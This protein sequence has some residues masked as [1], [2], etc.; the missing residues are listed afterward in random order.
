MHR[1]EY[2]DRQSSNTSGDISGILETCPYLQRMFVTGLSTM[3]VVQHRHIREIYL[4]GLPLH[5]SVI[6]AL[7][8]CEFPALETL[9]LMDETGIKA[10]DL[11]RSLGSIGA[12]RLSSLYVYGVELLEFLAI[13]GNASLPWNLCILAPHFTD[14]DGL[15]EVL[16]GYEALR[17]PKLRFDFGDKTFLEEDIEQLVKMGIGIEDVSARFLPDAYRE[18]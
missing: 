2:I 1:G 14:M 10:T 13:L 3:R 8:G 18:W 12:P 11:A 15:L 9:V 4:L 5:D 17:S 6:P 16:R 7:G